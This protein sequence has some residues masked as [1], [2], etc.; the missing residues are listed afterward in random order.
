MAASE[1]IFAAAR[2]EPADVDAADAR[3]HA[4]VAP[5]AQRE[6]RDGRVRGRLVRYDWRRAG[7]TAHRRRRS[8]CCKGVSFVARARARRWR[9]SGTPARARRRSSTCCCASTIR[10]ADASRSNGVDIREHAA[11]RAA[12][13]L[14]GYVQQDIFLFAGDVRTNIRL[15]NPTRR[16]AMSRGGGARRRRPH[17]RAAAR[18]ATTGARRARRVDQRR[19]AAAAVVRARHR[20]RSRR[21]SCSTR[22]RARSTA[23]SRRRSSAALA[24]LMADAR[25]SPIAHR[26]S[27]IV[28]ADEI[29]VLHHGEVRERGT[30][31]SS[32]RKRGL[33]ERLYRLQAGALPDARQ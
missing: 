20:G 17:D 29:L 26:L 23:R 30:H 33:Y 10:S 4:R 6:R 1:R 12:R 14:I 11:R 25:R 21:C 19:R 31:A 15:S 2:H 22:R 28:D 7:S 27:T 5:R 24:V 8:G 18:A 13:R 32:S 16:R 3:R 9:W